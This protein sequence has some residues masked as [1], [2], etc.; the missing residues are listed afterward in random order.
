MHVV[1][2]PQLASITL[3]SS[4]A[5]SALFEVQMINV[6]TS[7]AIGLPSYVRMT[8]EAERTVVRLGEEVTQN[9]DDPEE[10]IAAYNQSFA[11]SDCESITESDT[12]KILASVALARSWAAPA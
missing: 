11:A 1:Q 6:D 5:V 8:I 3:Q 4:G 12:G 9:A 7:T 10:I 2:R